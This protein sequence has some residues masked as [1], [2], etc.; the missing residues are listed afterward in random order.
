MKIAAPLRTFLPDNSGSMTV[1]FVATV[2]LLLAALLFSFEFGR[3]LWA[4][5]VVSRDVRDAVRYL[6][7]APAANTPQAQC[8]AMTGVPAG[9]PPGCNG[10]PMHFPWTAAAT[11]PAV[12]PISF[13]SAD[14]NQNGTVITIA[15]SVPLTLS[16]PSF[17]RIGSGY[18]VSLVVSDQA[19]RIGS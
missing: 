17:A 6:S 13:S 4:Y 18:T 11:F 9:S 1:E 5:D 14:F 7:R 3:A 16:F 8:L 10:N 2:P 12:S 15:A 19:R